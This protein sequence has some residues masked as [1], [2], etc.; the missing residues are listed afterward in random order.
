MYAWLTDALQETSRVVTANRRL[1]RELADAYGDQQIRDGKSVWRSPRIDAWSDWLSKQLANAETS[2]PIPTRINSHQ[3]RVLW[4]KCLRREV[5]DPLLNMSLLVRQSRES[6]T[7]LQEFNVPLSE[8]EEA[9]QGKDQKIFAAAARSYQSILDREG[10]IDESGTATFLSGLVAQGRVAVP[11]SLLFAGFDRFVPQ[12]ATL[13]VALREAGCEIQSPPDSAPTE[14]AAV[15][16]FENADA[17]MRAVGSW[18]RQQLREQPDASIAIVATHLEQ[19]SDHYARLV[20]EGFAPGWQTSGSHYKT[21]VNVSY[22]RQLS[23][24]PAIAVAVLALRWLH[25]DIGTRD[26]SILL[27]SAA[28]GA[29]ETGGRSRLEMLLRRIPDRSWT[30]A[31]VLDELQGQGKTEDAADWIA[32]VSILNEL[33]EE[34]PNRETPSQWAVLIDASLDKLGW[35][36]KATLSSEEFQLLNR[37]KELLNDL[38]RLDLVI[39]SMTLVEALRRVQL[40]AGETVFQ[41]QSDGA[42]IHL[43]GPLEAA[44]ME[45]DQL[46]IAGLSA[47]NW[48]PAGRPSPLIS[49]E[50][51][52]NYAMP[53]ATPEDTLAYAHRVLR[54]LLTS[55]GLSF[56]S[57]PLAEGDAEQ[58]VSGLL[59]DL[60]NVQATGNADPGW[61]AHNLVSTNH[62]EVAASD[63]VPPIAQ[64]EEV[65]GGAATIQNQLS[66]P[67]SAF[68]FGR[69]GIRSLPAISSGLPASLRGTLVHDALHA[70]YKELPSHAELLIWQESELRQRIGAAVG[71]AF[72]RH[73][74]NADATLRQVFAL[75]QERVTRLL[76]AVVLLDREREP[77]QIGD[78]E[79]ALDVVVSGV[80]L[81]LRIDRLDRLEDGS[82]VILDYK[83]GARK[84]FLDRNGDPNDMQLVVYA[85]AVK[86]PVA[87]LGLVNIDS[88]NVDIDAAGRDFTPRMDWDEELGRW[89]LQVAQAAEALQRGDVRVDGLQSTDS[90]RTLGLL[91]RIGELRREP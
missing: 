74:K 65:S 83:T 4:E 15:S 87:G 35:P 90:A 47:A 77:F 61:Y 76:Q 48:P 5:S 78:T 12:A 10:W 9:A 16:S 18:A 54:R 62:T 3:S 70:L 37:W 51:Q 13:L 66:E 36:G 43:L 49:R 33:R 24:Y 69:L 25:E 89:K 81:S 23:A 52:R 68:A 58:D 50:L 59:G 72:W 63:Q 46:W 29:P 80:R 19:N 64:D 85:S 21:A 30:P 75:E 60:S 2:I 57:Y 56:C 34:L 11:E 39:P 88:R 45:F 20:R 1:A 6:W 28:I 71:K 7:R 14:P 38:A 40:M 17:E 42:I 27:R 26:V 84:R 73:E 53:D 31:M 86:E 55:S 67:F 82:L 91:S 79:G 44:G 32:R 41:P 22:G 8:C